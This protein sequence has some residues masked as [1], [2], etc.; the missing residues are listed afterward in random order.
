MTT[1]TE[2]RDPAVLNATR[3]ALNWI[4][5]TSSHA[6][7]RAALERVADVLSANGYRVPAVVQ[8]RHALY[9]TLGY[10][11]QTERTPAQRI[12]AVLLGGSDWG[13]LDWTHLLAE[14]VEDADDAAHSR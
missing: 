12:H 13:D 11:Q 1:T 8:R 9:R 2:T 7:R 10:D 6:D 4:R 5:P 14:I 3:A